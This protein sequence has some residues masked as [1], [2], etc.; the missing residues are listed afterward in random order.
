MLR[1]VTPDPEVLDLDRSAY[2]YCRDSPVARADDS[3][4]QSTPKGTHTPAGQNNPTDTIHIDGRRYVRSGP[5]VRSGNTMTTP[6]SP[7]GRY[8][9]SS[10]SGASGAKS[11]VSG[12]PKSGAST[13]PT[14]STGQS[15]EPGPTSTKYS[16]EPWKPPSSMNSETDW[17]SS[18][19]HR[20]AQS[21]QREREFLSSSFTFEMGGV[22]RSVTGAELRRWAV[23]ETA[24][25]G[26]GAVTSQTEA[27]IKKQA[28]LGDPWAAM[29][30]S[31]RDQM[32]AG[33]P[34][35]L[36]VFNVLVGVATNTLRQPLTPSRDAGRAATNAAQYQQPWVKVKPGYI[37]KSAAPF[38]PR[39]IGTPSGKK[40]R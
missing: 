12:G 29:Y 38:V 10:I 11:G 18:S 7:V 13:H 5:P 16:S 4:H 14:R 34:S 6:L 23:Y 20:R 8:N 17:V 25:H 37:Q 26:A 2:E 19:I 21:D 32:E 3:G 24:H 22:S 1:W 31:V 9:S 39:R 35:Y 33:V 36:I 27:D 30:L 28:A 40:G 15:P